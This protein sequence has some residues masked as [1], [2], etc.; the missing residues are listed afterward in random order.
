MLGQIQLKTVP[1]VLT[2]VNFQDTTTYFTVLATEYHLTPL[3]Q[4]SDKMSALQT[5]VRPIASFTSPPPW[6]GNKSSAAPRSARLGDTPVLVARREE[7]YDIDLPPLDD[8]SDDENLAPFDDMIL[9]ALRA[10][11]QDTNGEP[12]EDPKVPFAI[13]GLVQLSRPRTPVDPKAKLPQWYNNPISDSTGSLDWLA[14]QTEKFDATL[15]KEV[16]PATDKKR[17]LRSLT[18]ANKYNGF[19]P[20][21]CDITAALKPKYVRPSGASKGDRWFTEDLDGIEEKH[22]AL[23]LALKRIPSTPSLGSSGLPTPL[24]APVITPPMTPRVD[25]IS[26]MQCPVKRPALSKRSPTPWNNVL[27]PTFSS[28]SRHQI[29]FPQHVGSDGVDSGGSPRIDWRRIH[30]SL[31]DLNAE[32]ALYDMDVARTLCENTSYA[33]ISIQVSMPGRLLQIRA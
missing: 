20:F 2:T 3:Y 17:D 6:T 5:Q 12:A 4:P 25:D 8:L 11:T 7:T 23:K 13:D 31:V 22:K 29:I 26:F 15:R 24:E 28:L 1:F 9:A 27:N 30:A 32:K 14:E 18:S 19:S 10:L 16:G 21:D 33:N